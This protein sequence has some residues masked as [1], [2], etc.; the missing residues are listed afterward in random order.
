MSEDAHDFTNP[1]EH[2]APYQHEMNSSC[3]ACAADC[4]A[5][6]WVSENALNKLRRLAEVEEHCTCEAD[7]HLCISCRADI[8][9]HNRWLEEHVSDIS[10]GEQNHV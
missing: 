9:A 7:G 8:Y 3:T 5:C 10:E 4:P 1:S 2:L 6:R